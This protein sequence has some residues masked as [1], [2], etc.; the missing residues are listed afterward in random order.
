MRGLVILASMG[1][2]ATTLTV[3]TYPKKRA[4]S[5]GVAIY[6]CTTPGT[7]ALTFDD[8]PFVYT[9]SVLDQLAS[10]GFQATFFLNGYNLGNIQDYQST[11]DRMINEGHQVASHTYG[12]P[13][14]A[15]L[16]DYDVEQQ[17]AL[18][19]NEFNQMI[20]K[21]PVYMRPPYFSFSD[22]TLQVLGRLG[23]K[24]VIADI[25][26]NDWRY[27][28]FGGAEPSLDSYNAG[29]SHGGSIVLMH[30]VHQNTVE[31]ILPLIIQATRRS[32]K[33]AVTVGECL[34]DP[35]TNWYRVSGGSGRGSPTT[36]W[37]STESHDGVVVI[38]TPKPERLEMVS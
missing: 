2:L 13:D 12:H 35:E 30:D 27:S 17:M 22:R 34:G 4:L 28:S 15:G 33:R 21:D 37:N 10:V 19:S 23:Y 18:L 6:S 31:N 8:G 29:L 7:V 26:T 14:L 32:G 25:D 11:V 5:A 1:Q 16:N 36:E 38:H 9:E 3:P 20:G 24:V